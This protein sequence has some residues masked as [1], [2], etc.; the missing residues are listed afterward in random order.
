MARRILLGSYRPAS[1]GCWHRVE[2]PT[3]AGLGDR[4]SELHPGINLETHIAEVTVSIDP[5][6]PRDIVLVGHCYA[7]MVIAALGTRRAGRIAKIVHLDAF[8]PDDG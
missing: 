3:L 5:D 6:G 4:A 7:G 2:T 8:V 1:D